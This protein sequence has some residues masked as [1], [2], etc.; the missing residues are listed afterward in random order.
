MVITMNSTTVTVST[1]QD[2]GI[3]LEKDINDLNSLEV[4]DH[5]ALGK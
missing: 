2:K 1:S 3:T 5:V 4:G